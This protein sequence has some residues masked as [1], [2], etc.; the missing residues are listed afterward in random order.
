M[1]DTQSFCFPIMLEVPDLKE[2][3]KI[4]KAYNDYFFCCATRSKCV[5][6]TRIQNK[7]ETKTVKLMT[8]HST[9][10]GNLLAFKACG[11]NVMCDYR[12]SYVLACACPHVPASETAGVSALVIFHVIYLEVRPLFVSAVVG[13]VLPQQLVRVYLSVSASN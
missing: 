4:F 3:K 12:F 1:V 13:Q 6:F 2:K 11:C 10:G 9:S 5:E 7:H 8:L